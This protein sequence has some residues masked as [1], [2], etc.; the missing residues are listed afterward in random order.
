M[1]ERRYDGRFEACD[2]ASKGVVDVG[3]APRVTQVHIESAVLRLVEQHRTGMTTHGS[4]CCIAQ[5]CK[6]QA[7][8][9]Q[10]SS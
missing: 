2:V 8:T 6:F 1:G 7:D 9:F 10:I 4:K 5:C 3:S